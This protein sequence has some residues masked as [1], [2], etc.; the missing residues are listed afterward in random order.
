LLRIR[1]DWSNIKSP[2]TDMRKEMEDAATCPVWLLY[3]SPTSFRVCQ[4]KTPPHLKGAYHFMD[5]QHDETIY[6]EPSMNFSNLST[7][8][9]PLPFAVV[10]V[11]LEIDLIRACIA[12]GLTTAMGKVQVAESG[13]LWAHGTTTNSAVSKYLYQF[14][15]IIN[16]SICI[17]AEPSALL[18]S[19]LRR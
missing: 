11:P 19:N 10:D 3:K 4:P 16:F 18:V 2:A 13:L 9:T 8:L 5:V 1:Y 6:N 7:F 17:S 12:H 15:N 14:K